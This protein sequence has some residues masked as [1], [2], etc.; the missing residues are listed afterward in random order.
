MYPTGKEDGVVPD[1]LSKGNLSL[2]TENIAR[3]M[4]E[5]I[6]TGPNSTISNGVAYQ[7][8]TY[9]H[10]KWPWVILPITVVAGAG[11]FLACSIGLNSR[12]KAA[13]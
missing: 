7:N 12:H 11:V 6:R 3:G 9:I 8:E 4:T 13:L 1:V 2:I 5:H 10:V